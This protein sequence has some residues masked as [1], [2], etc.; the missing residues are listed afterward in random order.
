MIDNHNS[1][2]AKAAAPTVEQINADKITQVVYFN[3][4]FIF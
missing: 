2:K 3:Y 4:L 1:S